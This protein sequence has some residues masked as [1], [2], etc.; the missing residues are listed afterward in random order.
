MKSKFVL[1]SILAALSASTLASAGVTA[2]NSGSIKVEGDAR[3]STLNGIGGSLNE[4]GN[5]LELKNGEL[6]LNGIVVYKKK[7]VLKVRL[8]HNGEN[9]SLT[10]NGKDVPLPGIKQAPALT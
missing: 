3:V 10:V 6:S 9:F 7:G 8:V 4:N 2:P 5:I 1:I